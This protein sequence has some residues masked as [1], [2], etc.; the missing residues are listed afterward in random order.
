[1]SSEVLQLDLIT[2]KVTFNTSHLWL[3]LISSNLSNSSTKQKIMQLLYPTIWKILCLEGKAKHYAQTQKIMNVETEIETESKI[4][5]WHVQE[6]HGLKQERT[7]S[8]EKDTWNVHN[9]KN[10]VYPNRP[11]VFMLHD[12]SVANGL[13]E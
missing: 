3:S 12:M 6:L 2:V 4:L 1:M 10:R 5:S 9:L 7:G 11:K 13:M 8:C